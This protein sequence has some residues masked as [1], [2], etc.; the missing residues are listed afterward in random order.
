MLIEGKAEESLPTPGR[1]GRRLFIIGGSSALLVLST[2]PYIDF[3]TPHDVR[4]PEKLGTTFSIQQCDY[5][6]LDKAE[7]DK[8]LITINELGPDVLRLCAYWDRIQPSSDKFDP[9]YLDRELAIVGRYPVEVTVALGAVKSPRYPEFFFP[10]WITEKYGELLKRKD[11]PIDQNTDLIKY[12]SEYLERLVEHLRIYPQ[13]KILQV[14]NEQ[15]NQVQVAD[16][17]TLSPDFTKTEVLLVRKTK[18]ADQGILA[19]A[20][21]LWW[22]LSTEEDEAVVEKSL[23]SQPDALGLN[24]YTKV[25]V[26]GLYL[27]PAIT[28]R[29]KLRRLANQIIDSQT[30]PWIAEAQAEPWEHGKLVAMDQKYY[31]SANPETTKELVSTLAN[32]GY[33]VVLLW[34][35]EY[36]HAHHKKYGGREWLTPMQELFAKTA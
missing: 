12:S 16:G 9:S 32:I 34:G 25:G 17:L 5:L 14:E 23:L 36:W 3:P 35:S 28:Q 10:S 30:D 8:A 11:V 20:S 33:R 24:V 27:E 31:P 1:M 7:R 4:R 2:V 15:Y 19:T 13:V 26:N 22:P 6:K 18:R 29:R 21:T